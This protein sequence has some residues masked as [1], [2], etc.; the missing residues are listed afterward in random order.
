MFPYCEGLT[1]AYW[2]VVL[3][4]LNIIQVKNINAQNISTFDTISNS[5]TLLHFGLPT[6]EEVEGVWGFG[7]DVLHNRENV[8]D[9]LLREGRLVA[10][11]EVVLLE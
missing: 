10:A 9:V 11:V 7:V 3:E 6:L 2:Y 8:Q 4:V 5:V 1:A